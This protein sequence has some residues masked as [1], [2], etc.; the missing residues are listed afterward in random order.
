MYSRHNVSKRYYHGRKYV[1]RA[2]SRNFWQ[3]TRH[4]TKE[5]VSQTTQVIDDVPYDTARSREGGGWF[6]FII[7]YKIQLPTWNKPKVIALGYRPSQTHTRENYYL[8][9]SNEHAIW[10]K[11]NYKYKFLVPQRHTPTLTC[12]EREGGRS[13]MWCS[14]PPATTTTR[15]TGLCETPSHSPTHPIFHDSALPGFAR[16]SPLHDKRLC[17][18]IAYIVYQ[19]LGTY[20]E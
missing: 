18:D 17:G 11:K 12:C 3:D 2:G 9:Q 6:N 8:P 16:H 5:N 20:T 1:S 7:G 14:L 13:R 15:F 4:R 10:S 19:N